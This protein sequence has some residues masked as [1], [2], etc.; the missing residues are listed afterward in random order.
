VLSGDNPTVYLP[1]NPMRLWVIQLRTRFATH[2]SLPSLFSSFP[3]D[4]SRHDSAPRLPPWQDQATPGH[5]RGHQWNHP[6]PNGSVAAPLP[7]QTLTDSRSLTVMG[8]IPGFTKTI[9]PPESLPLLVLTSNIGITLFL[10]LVGLEVDVRL[11]KRNGKSA[12]LISVL[13]LVVPLGLGSAIAVPLYHTF[14]PD[15]VNF[16]Y[17]ILFVAVAVGITAFPVLCRILTELKLLDTVVGLVVLAAG[18]GNDVV[19]W[20]LLA[21]TVALVNAS[22][23]LTALYV[24]LVGVGYVIFMMWPVK[25]AFRFLLKK[26]GSLATGQPT[27]VVMTVT[28]LMV[29]VSAFLTDIIGIHAI[30]GEFP[31]VPPSVF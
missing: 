6:W 2:F 18:V 30:F 27:T 9:F 28:L 24:L 23:G 5:C 21:L 22:N 3:S 12:A 31:T 26:S 7:L 13:G 29:F 20:I 8:H 11:M 25:W 17:F 16:G 14:I 19:G 4:Y 15:T 10:F 1:T